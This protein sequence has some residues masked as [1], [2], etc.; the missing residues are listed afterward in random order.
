KRVLVNI[1]TLNYD[2]LI[3]LGIELERLSYIGQNGAPP[4]FKLH[5]SC[6]IVPDIGSATISG[7]TVV[8][9]PTGPGESAAGIGGYS[10]KSLSVKDMHTFLHDQ[11]T[12]V[13]LLA[14]Y[15]KSKAVRDCPHVIKQVQSRWAASL[16]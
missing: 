15:H 13:P 7:I 5:G 1:A 16:N 9:P 12:L 6:N 2:L 4:V 8:V 10:A 3:E 11:Q 14:M